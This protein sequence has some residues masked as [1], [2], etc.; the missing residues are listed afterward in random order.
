M[1]SFNGLTTSQV[2]Q[3]APENMKP[4]PQQN[5]QMAQQPRKVEKTSPPPKK[6]EPTVIEVPS[7]ELKPE[8]NQRS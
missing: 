3:A 7:D 8:P 5:Q 6:E 1:I 4:E 2:V